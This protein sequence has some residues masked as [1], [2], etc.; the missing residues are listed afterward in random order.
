[1]TRIRGIRLRRG[2]RRGV[3]GRDRRAVLR[4]A[5]CEA[6]PHGA[7]LGK[8]HVLVIANES[9]SGSE[10]RDRVLAGDGER[11]EVD[12]LAPVLTSRVHLGVSDIDHELAEAHER[13][14]RSLVWA[15]A[16]GI[17][18]RGEVGD[19]SPITAFEDELRDFCADE[20]IVVTHPRDRET[21]Q[22]RGELE[23]LQRELNA[24]VTH[25]VVPDG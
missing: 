2:A 22:E 4:A 6:H 3:A 21:W 8:R 13:S 20:V 11:I 17:V 16:Q 24:P 7:A 23:R 19:P 14:G 9:L 5:A 25:V 18:A 10:L 12:V 15:R 1:M